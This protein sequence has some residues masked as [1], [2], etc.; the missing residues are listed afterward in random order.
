MR[1]SAVGNGPRGGLDRDSTLAS[2]R[3]KYF[4]VRKTANWICNRAGRQEPDY[5]DLEL[6]RLAVYLLGPSLVKQARREFDTR[7]TAGTRDKAKPVR[8]A[9]A[10]FWT[11][12]KR[13]AMERGIIS[14]PEL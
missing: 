10:A 7:I 1:G 11:I 5:R 6:A 9:R 12:V 8:G 3:H 14:E 4:S 13:M 2:R